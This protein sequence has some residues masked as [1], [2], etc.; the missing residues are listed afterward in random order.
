MENWIKYI[1]KGFSFKGLE[2]FELENHT[3]YS[4]TELKM[5]KNEIHVVS[6][7]VFGT[8]Q[9]VAPHIKKT[10][11]LSIAINSS[12]ILKKWS[13]P[14]SKLDIEQKVIQAFP[15]LDLHK[16]Y[17]EILAVEN[18]GMV[19]IGKRE[20]VNNLLSELE[21]HNIV[22]MRISLGISDIG[23]TIPYFEASNIQGSNFRIKKLD[24]SGYE[25]EPDIPSQHY[26]LEINGLD[27]SSTSLLSFSA[28]LGYFIS[29]EKKSNVTT[30]NKELEN[31]FLNYHFY[32]LGFKWGLGIVL[33][34]LFLNFLC[35]THYKAQVASAES[36][37]SSE[38]QISTLRKLEDEVALKEEKLNM[39]LGTKSSRSTFY[40]DRIANELPVTIRLDQMEYQPLK[41]PVQE[42]KSIELKLNSII[43]SGYSND[44]TQ[45]AQ[46]TD[47]LD[48]KDWIARI[49]ILHYGYVSKT[50]DEFTVKIEIHEAEQ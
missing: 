8:I 10:D 47:A 48:Q 32:N 42:H 49:E 44:K 33:G 22:P 25:F 41:R 3:F 16:F 37:S 12:Q 43:V 19:S 46:W 7:R 14:D 35:Y 20:Y 29:S 39:I 26:N 5:K 13:L 11:M 21:T 28:F 45:F 18:L 9:E 40:M 30:L 38:Q 1:I 31:N 17:F 23:T 34:I 50:S 24:N 2:I 15:N 4:L 27:M 36:V 6:E